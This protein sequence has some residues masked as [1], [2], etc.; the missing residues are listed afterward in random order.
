MLIA[1]GTRGVKPH[2]VAPRARGNPRR[3]CEREGRRGG[4]AGRGIGL[5]LPGAK[6][7][8]DTAS[9]LAAAS[10][11]LPYIEDALQRD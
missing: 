8:I 6:P 7:P 9:L 1:D 10:A 2:C 5:S 11:R 4:G 3:D